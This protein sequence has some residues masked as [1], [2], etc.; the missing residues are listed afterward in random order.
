[1]DSSLLVN[2]ATK[3]DSCSAGVCLSFAHC[4]RR[5][6]SLPGVWLYGYDFSVSVLRFRGRWITKLENPGGGGRWTALVSRALQEE[7][8]ESK[9]KDVPVTGHEGP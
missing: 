8:E 4:D 5:F 6:E 3:A 1:M 7:E 2:V 9:S